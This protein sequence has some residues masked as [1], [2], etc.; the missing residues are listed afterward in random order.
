[1][2]ITGP[3]LLFLADNTNSDVGRVSAMFSGRSA[4]IL[5]GSIGFS[6]IVNRYAKFQP[7]LSLGEYSIQ[8][9]Q[10]YYIGLYRCTVRR[11]HYR[12]ICLLVLS[13]INMQII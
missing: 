11:R 10:D 4:G 2:S 1:M 12:V 7:L 6:A 8:K 3:T 13:A 5:V 9:R